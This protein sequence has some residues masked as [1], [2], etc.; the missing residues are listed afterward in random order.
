LWKKGARFYMAGLVRI[1]NLRTDRT[2]KRRARSVELKEIWLSKAALLNR[3]GPK[4]E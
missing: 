4:H 2:P 1:Y 3:Y